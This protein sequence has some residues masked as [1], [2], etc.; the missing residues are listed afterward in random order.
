MSNEPVSGATGESGE[1]GVQRPFDP[2]AELGGESP[3]MAHLVDDECLDPSLAGR[4]EPSGASAPV[5]SPV[6]MNV[7]ALAAG[8][9]PADGVVWSAPH[10]GDLDVNLVQLGPAGEIARHVNHEVD[11][12]LVVERGEA[13]V[14]LDAT[15]VSMGPGSVVL[16]PRGT[17]RS[18]VAGGAGVAYLSVHRRR[19]PLTVGR[20]PSG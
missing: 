7:D 10:D 3:C 4:R 2:L 12:L 20:R 8:A 19:G 9:G 17:A 18:I 5:R 13:V 16:V 14:T 15:A 11:V 6:V 1:S